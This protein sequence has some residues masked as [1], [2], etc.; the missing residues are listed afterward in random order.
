MEACLAGPAFEPWHLPAFCKQAK[1]LL[2][3][4]ELMYELSVWI[5]GIN[6]LAELKPEEAEGHMTLQCLPGSLAD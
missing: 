3:H 1:Q 5:L 4:T 2:S 6:F